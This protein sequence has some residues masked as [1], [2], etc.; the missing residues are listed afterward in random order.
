[1]RKLYIN[2]TASTHCIEVEFVGESIKNVSR[3]S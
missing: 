1:M 3:V 2:A